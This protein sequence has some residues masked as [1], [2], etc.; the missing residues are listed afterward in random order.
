MTARN[1]FADHLRDDNRSMRHFI[2]SFCPFCI[3]GIPKRTIIDN[4]D[5][6]KC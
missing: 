1:K 4:G 5:R 2:A 3:L 6:L